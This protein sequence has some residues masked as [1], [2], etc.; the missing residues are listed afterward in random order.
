MIM[1]KKMRLKNKKS[2]RLKEILRK[3]TSKELKD[4]F[5]VV[6]SAGGE[7]SRFKNIKNA[8]HVQKTAY[9]LPSGETMI[10]RTVLMYKKAGFSNFVILLYHNADSVIKLLGD[11]SRF[12]VSIVYSHDPKKPVGRGGAIK[13]AFNKG[14]IH[15][16]N[17]LI[18]HNPDDQIIG[19]SHKTIQNVAK[20]HISNENSGALATA[21]MVPNVK[22]EFTGFTIKKGFVYD[23]EMYPFINIPTHIGLTVFS[24][25]IHKYFENLFDLNKKTDFEAVL[26]PL[27][28]KVKKL[29]AHMIPT[30]AWISVNDEK[31]L[32]KLISALEI[33]QKKKT[34]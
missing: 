21:V 23:V 5:L 18:V 19:E 29:A 8:G 6:L 9:I 7:S 30:G 22:H 2:K 26:F 27:L 13:H 34:K 17:Y 1:K 10:E 24:P 15:P 28:A 31:G 33:E 11:G 20:A 12:K 16:K 3:L 14:I 25:G 32:K 4:N